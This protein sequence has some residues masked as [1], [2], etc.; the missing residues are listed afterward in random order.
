[1]AAS[2]GRYTADI[3][4]ATAAAA[5]A[6]LHAAVAAARV[7]VA[8]SRKWNA[9]DAQRARC[10][11]RAAAVTAAAVST[12]AAHCSIYY[13]SGPSDS[14]QQNIS[15]PDGRSYQLPECLDTSLLNDMFAPLHRQ[16]ARPH[17]RLGTDCS[18][19]NSNTPN[20]AKKPFTGR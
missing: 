16:G 6:A 2:S 11:N 14:M 17:R 12:A 4:E 3:A 8:A 9:F 15:S 10:R 5:T 20:N 13:T 19:E 7:M 1:M 18:A